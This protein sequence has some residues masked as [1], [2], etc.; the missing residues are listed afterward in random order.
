MSAEPAR[1]ILFN[2]RSAVD[3]MVFLLLESSYICVFV[4]VCVWSLR[5]TKINV[6]CVWIV[7][8]ICY[9]IQI[10]TKLYFLRHMPTIAKLSWRSYFSLNC[11]ARLAKDHFN[12]TLFKTTFSIIKLCISERYWTSPGGNTPQSRR[13]TATGHPSQKLSKLDKADMQDTAGE[14]GTNS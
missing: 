1:M 3:F 6:F 10:L 9:Y 12:Q 2:P 4:C 14:V 11:L 5:N 8:F 13:C 7:Y